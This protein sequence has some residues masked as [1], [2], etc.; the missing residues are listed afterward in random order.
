M[1][2]PSACCRSQIESS[3]SRPSRKFLFVRVPRN[4][5]LSSHSFAGVAPGEVPKAE[6]TEL[7]PE[8]VGASPPEWLETARRAFL[9]KTRS[10]L[11][12]TPERRLW[13][14]QRED[15]RAQPDAQKWV[16]SPMAF[17]RGGLGRSKKPSIH[18]LLPPRLW[19]LRAG[20]HAAGAM[21]VVR[22]PHSAMSRYRPW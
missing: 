16:Y 17:H 5:V 19:S 6:A 1:S 12:E 14:I 13:A 8:A 10:A 3:Y 4:P 15:R 18:E 7:A 11:G 22:G 2:L 21:A 20:W 9:Y